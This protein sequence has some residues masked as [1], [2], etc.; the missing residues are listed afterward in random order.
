ML[1]EW[2]REEA[3]RAG[4]TLRVA[5][6]VQREIAYNS[7]SF[8]K[9]LE[10][11]VSD[12]ASDNDHLPITV[13]TPVFVDSPANPFEPKY[14]VS[15]AWDDA[16]KAI[17]DDLCADAEQRG[18][19]ILRD[20]THVGLGESIAK[21]MQRLSS[22]Q[23]VFVILSEKYLRSPYCMEEL[24]QVWFKCSSEGDAFR[25]RI[26]VFRLPDAKIGTPLERGHC[27]LYWKNEYEALHAFVLKHAD[28]LGQADFQ[29]YKRMQDFAHK[30]S[31]ILATIS[32]TLMPKDFEEFKARGFEA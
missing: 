9:A 27:A 2:V 17:V 25:D 18:L 3:G 24:F 4:C 10:I 13:K 11:K 22:G 15:Y 29:R 19:R 12:D 7:R 26:R 32:D 20:T 5:S 14:A 28:L 1:V 21:F 30:V 23:R 6:E 8:V 16:S 31:D